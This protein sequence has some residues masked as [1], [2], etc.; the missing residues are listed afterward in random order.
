MAKYPTQI[1][2]MKQREEDAACAKSCVQ[3]ERLQHQEEVRELKEQLAIEAAAREKDKEE[4]KKQ[5]EEMR[6]EFHQLLQ[7]VPRKHVSTILKPL[8]SFKFPLLMSCIGYVWN[9]PPHTGFKS[10]W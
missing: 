4:S 2:L 6:A 5:M 7:Q 3:E 10:T 1:A 8:H 9:K